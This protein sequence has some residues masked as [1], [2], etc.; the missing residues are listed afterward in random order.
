MGSKLS[1]PVPGGM[2][3]KKPEGNNPMQ[4]RM[5]LP[6]QSER[7]KSNTDAPQEEE[8]EDSQFNKMIIDRPVIKNKKKPKR[9][10]IKLSDPPTV[11]T[12]I[13]LKNQT[14]IEETNEIETNSK[15]EQQNNEN[16]EDMT[17]KS[18]KLE[19]FLNSSNKIF[20]FI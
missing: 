16:P 4:M 11:S 3:Q 19:D 15:E 2:P 5:I 12:K 9:K 1:F 8:E 6:T 10:V 14:K 20:N 13:P 17:N 18:G 7:I